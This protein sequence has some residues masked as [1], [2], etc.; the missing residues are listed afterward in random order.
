M[1]YAIIRFRKIYY[2]QATAIEPIKAAKG[3]IEMNSNGRKKSVDK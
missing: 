3:I 1:Q 2:W